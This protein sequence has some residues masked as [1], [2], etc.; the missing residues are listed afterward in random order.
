[1]KKVLKSS[2]FVIV[3]SFGFFNINPASGQNVD[4]LMK[5]FDQISDQLL[6]RNNDTNYIQNYGNQIGVK[7][8]TNSK[9]NY[10]RVLDL[11]NN[12]TLRYS[13]VRDISVGLGVAYKYFAFDVTLSLGL[14]KNSGLE[15]TRSFDF[16]GRLFSSKQLVSATLQYYQGYR[17]ANVNGVQLDP[18]D[19]ETR[20]EDLRTVNLMMQYMYAFNYT[21]FSMKAPFVFNERQKKSAGSVIAGASFSL[22]NLDSDSSIVPVTLNDFFTPEASLTSLNV[23]NIGVKVGYMYTYVYKEHY[24]ITLNLSPGLVFNYGDYSVDQLE[25]LPTGLNF[26]FSSMNSIGYNGNRLFGGFN[27]IWENYNVKVASHT[28]MGIGSGKMTAFIGYRF[29]KK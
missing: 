11:Q 23:F 13:P 16:Q 25:A 19:E 24:F 18:D 28:R 9:F 1:M 8:V 15:N 17:L 4:T 12:T 3:L 10:F 21:K 5:V 26:S 7:L 22:F 2:V 6:Y 29:G 14:G 20:R 27:L